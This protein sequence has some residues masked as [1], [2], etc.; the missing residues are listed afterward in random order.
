MALSSDADSDDID[1]Y[2]G[3]AAVVTGE[4]QARQAPQPSDLL[5]GHRLLHSAEV[6]AGACLHFDEDR[7]SRCIVSRDD[8][9][10]AVPATPVAVEHP[11][12]KRIQMLDRQVL[13][14]R[15]N[16]GTSERSHVSHRAVGR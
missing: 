7:G 15:S 2:G 9:Q 5:R 4:P 1:A 11:K 14:K 12:T 16:L 10:L 8:V 6:V 3:P 13:A